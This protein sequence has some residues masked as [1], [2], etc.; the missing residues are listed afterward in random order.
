[1]PWNSN[2]RQNGKKTAANEYQEWSFRLLVNFSK[3]QWRKL[4]YSLQPNTLPP[5]KGLDMQ[6]LKIFNPQQW[7]VKSPTP[8][9][10]PKQS[11]PHLTGC[12]WREKKMLPSKCSMYL[13]IRKQRINIA[14]VVAENLLKDK[15]LLTMTAYSAPAQQC[16]LLAPYRLM[17]WIQSIALL[18]DI[19]II[20]L[21]ITNSFH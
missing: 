16:T 12:I 4:D 14:I 8:R 7:G 18:W 5:T 19:E 3:D 2:K 15:A 13:K 9:S 21:E 1:M 10:N 20:L 11:K 6:K 17:N